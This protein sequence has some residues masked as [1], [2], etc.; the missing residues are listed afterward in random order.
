[1]I[2]GS[3]VRLLRREDAPAPLTERTAVHTARRVALRDE[4]KTAIEAGRGRIAAVGLAFALGFVMLGLRAADLAL[5]DKP[6]QAVAA[7]AEAE[8]AKRGGRAD[9]VDRNGEILATTLDTHSLYADPRKVWDAGE[10]AKALVTVLPELN[11]ARTAERLRERRAFVWIARNL[12]PTQRQAVFSLGLPGV[13]FIRE[14]KRVYPRTR[15]ASHVLGFTDIDGEGSSGLELGLESDLREYGERGRPMPVSIDMRVQFALA[16][17]LRAAQAEFSAL[18]AA[19][20]VM[21]VK[22]GEV[23]AMASLPD[24]DPNRPTDSDPDARR[25][26][27]ASSLYEMGSTFKAFTVAMALE[28]GVADLESGYDASK[29]IKVGNHVIHDYHAENRWL[30]VSEIFTH[31]SNI[32]SSKMALEVGADR[33]RAFLEGL[34]LLTRPAGELPEIA[35]PLVPQHWGEAT[36]AT[37][38]FGHGVAVTPLATASAFASIANGGKYVQPTFK[39]HPPGR[40]L[41]EG[42]R[43][44]SA[45]T[46]Q[47][48]LDLMRQ[49]VTE[50]TG[51]KAE[52]PGYQV[53]GKTGTAE[54][55]KN[56][57]Y[58][59]KDLISSFAAIFP[60]DE[61]RY[62][63]LVLLDEPRGTPETFGYATAGW[64]AAPTAGKVVSRIAPMLGVDRANPDSEPQLIAANTGG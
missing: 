41:P 40:E 13:G 20:V 57:G 49:V 10:T 58:S 62:V 6:A 54:K 63:V 46:S 29:P 42:K 44:M 22:T 3:R 34:G 4:E 27:A 48:V 64:T 50:G 19:G 8:S 53:A 37:V 5:L 55:P 31:S 28:D 25:N 9:I 61:P 21:D 52:A 15:L 2:G 17:E 14:P 60:H 59:R 24:F 33:Q 39:V 43:I 56:G 38:S 11:E 12:T 30:T 26:R 23:L 47:N 18:A 35:D 16:D 36:T 1:M 45:T 51:R 32:G 7:V